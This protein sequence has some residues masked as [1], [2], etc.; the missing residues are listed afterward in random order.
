MGTG[1][2]FRFSKNDPRPHFLGIAV[3]TARGMP[4]LDQINAQLDRLAAFQAGPFPVISLYLNTSPD[5]HG[6]DHFEPFLK[7]ELNERI[8]TFEPER[9]ERASLD[10]DAA[11]IR[12]YLANN[13]DASTN[14]LT[15]FACSGA[16]LF[17]TVQLAAPI[18]EHRLFI[19]NLP[20]LYPLARLMD[21]YPRY[22]VLLADT[23]AARIFVFAVNALEHAE[24]IQ[25]TK[26]KRHSMGGWAQARY[27]RH[28]ENYHLHHA[29]RCSRS[30]SR[31]N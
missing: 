22:A 28:V 6:R 29:S 8:K 25:G 15:V 4:T 11:K 7:K 21:S 12:A 27:Q 13:L 24:T 2:I 20:H 19:S 14:G 16:H 10:A 9:P 26:T 31:R 23:N 5:Q 3:A 18:P 1:I 17:E 30:G